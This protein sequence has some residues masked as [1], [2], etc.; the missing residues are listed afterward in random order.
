MGESTKQRS[1]LG[2]IGNKGIGFKSVFKLSACPEVHSRNFH[3]RFDARS[4]EGLSFVL[5]LPADIPQGW[6][7]SGGTLIR[8][9][10]AENEALQHNEDRLAL[11]RRQEATD[12]RRGLLRDV[13]SKMLLFLNRLR[14]V[15]VHDETSE[16]SRVLFRRDVGGGRIRLEE[17]EGDRASTTVAAEGESASGAP[18]SARMTRTTWMCTSETIEAPSKDGMRPTIMTI[19]VPWPDEDDTTGVAGREPLP[20]QDVFAYLPLRSYGFRFILQA[21]WDIPAARESIEQTSSW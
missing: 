12:F 6:D 13:H 1:E 2:A 7:S 19:A 11:G 17:M 10:L 5:P 8:L 3:F 21:D 20:V 4:E 16:V 18:R 14:A 9:P 15:H